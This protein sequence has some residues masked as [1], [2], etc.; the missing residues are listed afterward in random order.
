MH[1]NVPGEYVLAVVIVII[2]ENCTY[3]NVPGEYVLAIIIIR[4]NCT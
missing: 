1:I 2:R 3:I 4:E